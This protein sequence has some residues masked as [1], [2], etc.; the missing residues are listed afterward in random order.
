MKKFLSLL[1]L[2]VGLSSCEEDIQFNTPAVQ[3]LK[4]N[5]LWKATEYKA[6]L[7]GGGSLII[8][9]TNGF[10]TVVLRTASSTPGMSF[11]LGENESNKATYSLDA[12]GISFEYQTG[13]D[14]GDGLIEIS[15]NPDETDITRGF[16]SGT[17]RFNALDESGE[18]V[19][20]QNGFFYKVPIQIAP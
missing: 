16:I 3:G 17:F 13:T 12:D 20:F 7:G 5:E 1:V 19:N 14:L 18:V 6:I 4:D 2:L 8:E 11:Q 10:E 9:A 15:D